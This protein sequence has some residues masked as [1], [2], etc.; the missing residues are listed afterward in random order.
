MEMSVRL[1]FV[2]DIHG[3]L[4]ALE[5][6]IADM[7]GRG[8]D[9]VINLGY[10]PSGPLLPRETAQSPTTP[11]MPPVAGNQQRPVLHSTPQLPNPS[12]HFTT[13]TPNPQKRPLG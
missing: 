1:A 7:H 10:T 6:V 8:I 9:H 3:N 5:A 2:S 4:A 12:E 13:P 11:P